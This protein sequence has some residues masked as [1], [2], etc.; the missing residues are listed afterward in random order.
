MFAFSGL[1]LQD[2]LQ[3]AT[4]NSQSLRT[5]DS[6]VPFLTTLGDL[7][8]GVCLLTTPGF[9]S[10]LGQSKSGTWVDSPSMLKELWRPSGSRGHGSKLNHQDSGRRFSTYQGKVVPFWGS[11]RPQLGSSASPLGEA[12]Q[13]SVSTFRY[14]R[15]RP[16]TPGSRSRSFGPTSTGSSRSAPLARQ[17]L[18]PLVGPEKPLGPK[19]QL[20]PGWVLSLPS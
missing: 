3:I 20:T 5:V 12:W 7:S 6:R 19:K 8:P 1:F 15:D 18:A 16:W 9:K 14:A 4:H 10:A 11:L 2:R 13:Y 17:T